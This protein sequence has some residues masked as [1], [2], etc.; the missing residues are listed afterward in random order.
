VK[1]KDQSGGHMKKLILGLIILTSL[2]AQAKTLGQLASEQHALA[3][4]IVA[5]HK[6]N[7]PKTACFYAGQYY[8]KTQLGNEMLDPVKPDVEANIQIKNLFDQLCRD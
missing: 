8:E 1:R 5:A 3:E 4:L 7:K 6:S 2:S